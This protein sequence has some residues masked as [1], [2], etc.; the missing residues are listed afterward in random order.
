MRERIVLNEYHDNNDNLYMVGGD[1]GETSVRAAKADTRDDKYSYVDEDGYNRYTEIQK[2][3]HVTPL[4]KNIRIALYVVRNEDKTL[5]MIGGDWG[6][7]SVRAANRDMKDR[8]YR[9]FAR[10]T[11][12][13]IQRDIEISPHG[14]DFIKTDHN[15]TEADNLENMEE[16][17]YEDIV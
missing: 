10:R 15:S 9:Y 6:A 4:Y 12:N 5:Y 17:S 1:W 7:T 8:V 16:I 2:G 14:D 3:A 11:I 13:G